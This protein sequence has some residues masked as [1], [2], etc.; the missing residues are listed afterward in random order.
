MNKYNNYN[1]CINDTTIKARIIFLKHNVINIIILPEYKYN[2]VAGT[3][4]I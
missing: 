2:C 4:H 1:T 3:C